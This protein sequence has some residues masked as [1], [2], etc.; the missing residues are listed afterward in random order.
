MDVAR[1]V[2]C[3][4]AVDRMERSDARTIDP[5][6]SAIELMASEEESIVPDLVAELCALASALGR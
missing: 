5:V 4:A 3:S 6:A 2:E 1:G